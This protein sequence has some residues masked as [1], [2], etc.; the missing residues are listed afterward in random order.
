VRSDRVLFR[1]LPDGVLLL[2]IE[3]GD[4]LFLG[5]PGAFLWELLAEPTSLLEAVQ[6]LAEAHQTDPEVVRADIEPVI[7]E[8]AQLG[9]VRSSASGE[10][11]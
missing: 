11:E 2:P 9:V 3:G 7:E 8:L 6:I 1:F 5:G 4:P 10:G